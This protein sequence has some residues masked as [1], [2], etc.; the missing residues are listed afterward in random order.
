MISFRLVSFV[1]AVSVVLSGCAGTFRGE[2]SENKPRNVDPLTSR[3]LATTFCGTRGNP[4]CSEDGD[5]IAK[6]LGGNETARNRVVLARMA[7]IDL[8]Y[9]AY[10]TE[11]KTEAQ[12]SGFG[13][14]FAAITASAIA[15][16]TA[17]SSTQASDLNLASTVL[18]GAQTSFNQEVLAKQTIGAL[19]SQMRANRATVKAD[20]YSKLAGDKPENYRLEAALGDLQLY[21]QAG[22]L[23]AALVGLNETAAEAA[24]TGVGKAGEAEIEL[25]GVASNTVVDLGTVQRDDLID[26]TDIRDLIFARLD[27]PETPLSKIRSLLDLQIAIGENADFFGRERQEVADDQSRGRERTVAEIKQGLLGT[28]NKEILESA[29]EKLK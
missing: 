26:A 25:F 7:Q 24:K 18:Q 15:G 8:R 5:I 23:S 11:L 3:V 29:L 16:S 6:A 13:F 27:N 12:K 9:H 21:R 2:P 4:A 14:S 19:I 22:T 28:E 1:V 17:V 20:I 10:E